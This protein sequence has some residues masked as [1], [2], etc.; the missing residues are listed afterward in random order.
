MD[1]KQRKGGHNVDKKQLERCPSLKIR[2]T[3]RGERNV[4]K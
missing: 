4:K 3:K 2:S 1:Q